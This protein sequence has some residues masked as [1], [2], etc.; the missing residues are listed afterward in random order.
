MDLF[1]LFAVGEKK[2]LT[3]ISVSQ[4]FSFVSFF[5]SNNSLNQIDCQM[6]DVAILH[7]SKN[8]ENKADKSTKVLKNQT[9]I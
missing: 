7:L 9:D 3:S 6:D 8:T 4:L 2:K 5:L 1:M